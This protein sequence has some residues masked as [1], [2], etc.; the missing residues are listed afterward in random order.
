MNEVRNISEDPKSRTTV[1]TPPGV[2]IQCHHEGC[3][4]EALSQANALLRDRL[5]RDR[6]R[7]SAIRQVLA[8]VESL[9]KEFEA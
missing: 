3:Q 5:R 1:P 4:H 7:V 2:T 9:L 8:Q 6:A